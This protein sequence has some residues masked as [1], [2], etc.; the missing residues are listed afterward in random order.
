MVLVT[1]ALSMLGCQT[2]PTNPSFDVSVDDARAAIKQMYGDRKRLPRP[3]VVI[4]GFADPGFATDQWRLY[5]Q[6]TT[7]DTPVITVPMAFTGDFNDCRRRIMEHVE[8][9]LFSTDPRWSAEVD[10]VAYSMG[11]LAARYAAT[12]MDEPNAPQRRLKIVRLFTISSPHRGAR[13]AELPGVGALRRDMTA[14]SDFLKALDYR[15][16]GEPYELYPYVR[17]DDA[18]VGPERAAP[19]GMTPWWIAPQPGSLAHIQAHRDPRI[20]ADILRRLRGE[21]PYT[22]SPPAPLPK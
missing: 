4:G 3:V 12:A 20:V 19:P 9:E 8:R 11:G 16:A 10:V 7:V 14:D 6:D 21:E 22:T 18:I 15:F 5:I 2:P 1:A 13:L 17:L